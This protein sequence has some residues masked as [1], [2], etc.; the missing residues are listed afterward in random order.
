[1][2]EGD[3]RAEYGDSVRIYQT[4][5]TPLYH[6]LI[7]H[8]PRTAMKLVIVGPSERVVGCH[9]IGPGADAMLQGYAVAIN[10]GAAK[11]DFDKTVAIQQ[12]VANCPARV[13]VPSPL[14]RLSPL[15]FWD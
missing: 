6:A 15:P 7:R 9:V 1:M 13:T 5:F 10:L 14:A 12:R 4:R 3:A 8:K 11:V 2:N